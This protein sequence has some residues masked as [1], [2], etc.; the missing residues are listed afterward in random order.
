MGEELFN[1][2]EDN[3][4]EF[5]IYFEQLLTFIDKARENQFDPPSSESLKVAV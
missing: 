1:I 5:N 3:V 2:R 4:P